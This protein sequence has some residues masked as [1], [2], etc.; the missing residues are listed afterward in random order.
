MKAL[1]ATSLLFF[2]LSV[3]GQNVPFNIERIVANG[4]EVNAKNKS[5]IKLKSAQN[6]ILIEATNLS[7][8]SAVYYHRL[9][10][11]DSIWAMSNYPS[12]H[13]QNLSGG[14][15]V[16]E[17]KAKNY[18]YQTTPVSFGFEV[19]DAI[20]Q[21]YWFWPSIVFYVV[22]LIGI[23]I[24]FFSLYDLRQKLKVQDIRNRIAADLH[25]EVGSNLNSIAI[26]VELLRKKAPA[27][28][29]EILDKITNNSVES[30]QLMQDTIWA[31][32]A[33]NDDITKF[34]ARM[35]N[36]ATEVLSAKSIALDFKIEL[37]NKAPNLPM[38]QRK[39]VYL[40]FK[41]AINNI[42]KHSKATK[43]SVELRVMNDE[44]KITI[45]DNGVGFDTTQIFEGNGL[46]NFMTRAEASEMQVNVSSKIGKG[47]T[48][49]SV[50]LL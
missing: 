40:I 29:T 31:I 45:I 33:K 10:G 26:F 1:F 24:Y 20:W 27:E 25:D 4:Q 22:F 47:T 8:D 12:A 14:Q 18:F 21:K 43:T 6:K 3:I 23:V 30:V 7:S 41:E 38:D 46:T 35:K 34:I 44:L 15:Y 9:I 19:E 49:E 48:V 17:I 39:N 37:T 50:V 13:Y 2:S 28:L 16:F 36:F 42:A 11:Y 32:Q 5:K